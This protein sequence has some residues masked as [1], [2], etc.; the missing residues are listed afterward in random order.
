MAGSPSVAAFATEA[1]R[2]EIWRCTSQLEQCL[3]PSLDAS[4]KSPPTLPSPR[5]A[6]GALL[7]KGEEPSHLAGLTARRGVAVAV[8]SA[9][10]LLHWKCQMWADSSQRLAASLLSWRAC[11][12]EG[13]RWL[14]E[15]RLSMQNSHL[16]EPVVARSLS[17]P[18]PPLSEKSALTYARSS[19]ESLPMPL[20]G[21]L[22]CLE[23]RL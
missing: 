7:H 3:L 12:K 19:A 17:D 8:L 1:L 13:L 21:A 2:T 20:P 23:D 9:P 16:Q 22:L 14:A 6:A 5:E 11:C 4:A 18:L 10:E 15:G